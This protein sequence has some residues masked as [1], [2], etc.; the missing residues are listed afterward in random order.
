MLRLCLDLAPRTQL[1]APCPRNLQ[2][3]YWNGLGYSL[4]ASSQ[5]RDLN[6]A[7]NCLQ[8]LYHR[9]IKEGMRDAVQAGLWV[10]GVSEGPLVNQEPGRAGLRTARTPANEAP[11]ASRP[12]SCIGL[13]CKHT[14]CVS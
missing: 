1:A 4:Q 11:P 5:S 6:P 9:A 14:L 12:A 13:P 10:Q 7:L 3:E 2:A 8:F